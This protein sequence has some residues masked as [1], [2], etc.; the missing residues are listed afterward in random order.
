MSEV[1]AVSAGSCRASCLRF[2]IEGAQVGWI[3]PHVAPLLARYP[4]VFN[5]PQGGA[6]SLCSSLDSYEKRSEAVDEVLQTLRKEESLVFL[7]G[8]RNEVRLSFCFSTNNMH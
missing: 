6:V 5:P 4:K 7:K 3:P 2:E 8:W 1:W